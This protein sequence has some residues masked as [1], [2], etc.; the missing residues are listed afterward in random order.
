VIKRWIFVFGLAACGGSPKPAPA[1]APEPAPVP[2]PAPVASAASSECIGAV[3]NMVVVM[4]EQLRAQPPKVQALVPQITQIM[5]THCSD[6][7]WAPA[8]LQCMATVKTGAEQTKCEAM[9]TPDQAQKV[10]SELD[11]LIQTANQ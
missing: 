6:D 11:A 1:P 5:T 3:N 10:T 4:A 8:T 7:K 9:L 2:V